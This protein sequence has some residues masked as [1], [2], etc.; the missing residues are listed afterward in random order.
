MITAC[1]HPLLMLTGANSYTD[2]L[3]LHIK[4]YEELCNCTAYLYKMLY[5]Y[6]MFIQLLHWYNENQF[7]IIV[8]HYFIANR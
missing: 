8:F 3:L 4:K 7:K 5:L 6:Y 1:M 2:Q